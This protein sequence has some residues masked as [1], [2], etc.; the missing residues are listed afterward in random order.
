ML[1]SRTGLTTVTFG[2]INVTS[3]SFWRRKKQILNE[4]GIELGPGVHCLLGR[5]GAGK[6]TLIKLLVGLL[7]TA[8]GSV[9]IN[10]DELSPRTLATLTSSLGYLA[11]DFDVDGY[12]RVHDFLKY[13]AWSKGLS[14]EETV[15]RTEAVL[16]EVDLWEQRNNRCSTLSGGMKRRLGL[17]SAVVHSPSVLVLDEPTVG[18]D[19]EQRA[20]FRA[21]LNSLVEKTET[22]ILYSTHLIEDVVA[23]ADSVVFLDVGEVLFSGTLSEFCGTEVSLESVEQA[24]TRHLGESTRS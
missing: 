11:Q 3:L 6:T 14:Q 15:V 13:V 5:N 19:P 12:Y 24:F 9:S 23:M 22:C 20:H 10:G 16:K 1:P 2:H 8:H 4:V 21:L 7:N 17:A 18:L